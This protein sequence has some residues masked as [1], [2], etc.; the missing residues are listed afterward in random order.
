MGCLAVAL[1]LLA[2]PALCSGEDEAARERLAAAAA[3]HERGDFASALAA[4]E[5][6]CGLCAGGACAASRAAHAEHTRGV[7]LASLGRK[8]DAAAA[9]EACLARDAAHGHA[10]A[11]R[12]RPATT[13]GDAAAARGA[14]AAALASPAAAD[15]CAG[16]CLGRLGLL[17]DYAL[18][19]D[20]VDDHAAAVAVLREALARDPTSVQA[21]GNYA[22]QLRDVGDLGGAL[23]AGRR[24]LELDPNSVPMLHNVALIEQR[25]GNVSGAVDL[26]RKAR[27]LGVGVFQ[28]VASLAHHE[29]YRGNISGARALYEEALA[30]ALAP[31]GEGRDHADSVLPH[32]YDDGDHMDR[33]WVAYTEALRRLLRAPTLRIV[34]PLHS[35]GSGALG[36]YLEYVGYAD[37]PPPEQEKGAKF[38]ISKAPI[39]AVFH[40]PPRRLLARVY[41]RGARSDLAWRAPFL[42]APRAPGKLRVGFLSAFFFTHSVGL[43]TAGVVETLDR[44]RFT[45]A[46]LHVA[47]EPEDEL[48]A[49][50][51]GAA[52][53]DVLVFCEVGM[54]TMTYFLTFARLARRSA[55]FWGHAVTSGVA[56]SDGE[57]AGAAGAA[58]GVDYFVSPELFEARGDAAGGQDDYSETLWLMEGLTTRFPWPVDPDPD[59]E[60]ADVIAA[61]R[62]T[63]YLVPQTLYK[64]HPDFD[65]LIAGVLRE[66]GDALVAMPEAQLGEWTAA[67]ADRWARSIPEDVRARV[68]FFRRLDFREFVK[69]AQLA[70][71]VLDPFPVGGGRS[72]LEILSTGTPIVLLEPRTS[73]L[74]LTRGM[75]ELMG[76]PCPACVTQTPEAFVAAA[77][78]VAKFDSAQ[79]RARILER[80]GVLYENDGVTREWEAFLAHTGV[81]THYLVAVRDGEDPAA[82]AESLGDHIGAEDVKRRWLAALLQHGANGGGSRSLGAAPFSLPGGAAAAVDVREGDDLH[83]AAAWFAPPGLDDGAVD[84]VAAELKRRFPG[85]GGAPWLAARFA[86]DAATMRGLARALAVGDVARHGAVCRVVVVD[87]ASS[88]EDR[89]AMAAAFPAFDFLYKSP[90]HKGHARSMNA[91]LRVVETP[92][93]LYLEDDWLAVDGAAPR[94]VVGDALAVLEAAAEPLVQPGH[95][96]TY[97]PGFTL[98]PALW[99]LRALACAFFD[100]LGEAPVFDPDDAEFER[101]FSLK[102][103]DA[104]LRVAYLPRVTLAHIGVDESAYA[105]N[106]VSRPWDG[107]AMKIATMSAMIALIVGFRAALFAEGVSDQCEFLPPLIPQGGSLA[108]RARC[109]EL[110]PDADACS[111]SSQYADEYNCRNTL[112]GEYDEDGGWYARQTTDQWIAY[113]LKETHTALLACLEAFEAPS[114][115]RRVCAVFGDGALDDL[116]GSST[117]M[118][119]AGEYWDGV[120]SDTQPNYGD[121]KAVYDFCAAHDD[122][123]A[124]CS[125]PHLALYVRGFRLG[126]CHNRGPA[127][128]H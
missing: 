71:V 6:A 66:D 79:I 69:L 44:S 105:L 62:R 7:V 87:D 68:V 30:I 41:W 76:D 80:R 4:A 88:P 23:A 38:P 108:S 11:A 14:Y 2:L 72:S 25:L 128:G 75:Y 19:L 16:P 39:S 52:D 112:D 54:N 81:E 18:A 97:W 36:Y 113:D 115:A 106:N 90:A 94:D 56:R 122:D 45:V 119:S 64:L 92:Y 58:G 70:D 24:G 107:H 55:L 98:N 127:A 47:G 12:S 83:Q 26:W 73:V 53:L 15:G 3:A 63:L 109:C 103:R 50:L 61:P 117:S 28:P 17:N 8:T 114:G 34:D 59:L 86:R 78:R 10:A 37:L 124:E 29:G 99:D 49:K 32:I 118:T 123:L 101:S 95:A 100:V 40:S 102:A 125:V 1:W 20:A 104:G 126:E 31:G 91:L 22:I 27:D 120:Y 13:T 110:L 60:I 21:A 43:L 85:H 42:D 116:V 93:L 51:R 35:T 77:V 74:Q 96:F 121:S 84:Q 5:A 33:V 111:V 67:L 46:V 48:T 57:A 9:F 89:A 65:A 82:V